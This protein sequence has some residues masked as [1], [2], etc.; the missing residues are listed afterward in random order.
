MFQNTNTT[1]SQGSVGLACAIFNYQKMGYNILV[2]LVD[3]QDY[4][5]VIEKNQIF[6]TVQCKTT[7]YKRNSN[8]VVQLAKVRPNKTQNII[9]PMA[10]CSFL[11]ILC[12][13]GQCYS[14]PFEE[15]TSLKQLALY[16]I[17]DKFKI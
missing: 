2:P 9:R 8:Y 15:L 7:K 14:I 10:P 12:E 11:F 16:S 17:Y 1:V 6:Y 5:L 3:N 4:D 13:D